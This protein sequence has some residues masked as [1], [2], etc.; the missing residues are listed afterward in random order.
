MEPEQAG[1]DRVLR[2]SLGTPAPGLSAD[3]EKRLMR[4]VQRDSPA[5]ARY[6]RALLAGYGVVSAVTCAGLMRGQGMEWGPIALLT[7]GPLAVAAAAPLLRRRAAA[8][9]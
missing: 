9:S 2:Q 7:L 1:I 4:E 3:F 6:R 5:R 8:R